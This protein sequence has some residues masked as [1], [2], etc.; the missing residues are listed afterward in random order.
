MLEWDFG[1]N[2][3]FS[4]LLAFNDVLFALIQMF[5]CFKS[6][7]MCLFIFFSDLSESSMFVSSAK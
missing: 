4:A 2:N 3:V 5:N 1:L 7:L 6:W